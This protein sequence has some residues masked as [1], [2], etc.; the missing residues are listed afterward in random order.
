MFEGRNRALVVLLVLG[1]LSAVSLSA[2]DEK[3][4]PEVLVARHLAAIGTAEARAAAQSREI[5]GMV[6]FTEVVSHTINMV[7]HASMVSQGRTS[8]TVFDFATPGYKA[9]EFAFDGQTHTVSMVEPGKRSMLGDFLYA[10]REILREG[11]WGGTMS[12]AWPLLNLSQA[13]PYL[14]YQGLKKVNK[15][16]LHALLYEPR[17]RAGNGDLKIRLYFEPETF[18]HVL[19][20]YTLT[21]HDIHGSVKT[22][23]DEVETVLEER[24]SDFG[25]EGGIT[26]PRHWQIRYR[27]S[28]TQK[29]RIYQWEMSAETAK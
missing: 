14:T 13:A 23:T 20:I 3:L 8:K 21:T 5:Q 4:T 29:P 2:K 24:F 15:Q 12:T 26:L 27:Q 25:E 17:K 19:T 18:R 9:E 7:G 6:A 22:G 10:Q 11:L 16:S 1:V 28:D